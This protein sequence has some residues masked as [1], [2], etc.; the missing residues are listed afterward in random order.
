MIYFDIHTNSFCHIIYITTYIKVPLTKIKHFINIQLL[1]YFK[2][3]ASV[4]DHYEI[5]L[6]F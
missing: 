3:F 6:E 1:F 4:I 2:Y 5:Y